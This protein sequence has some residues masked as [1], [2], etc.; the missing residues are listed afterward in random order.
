MVEDFY[1]WPLFILLLLSLG[2]MVIGKLYSKKAGYVLSKVLLILV[3][4]GIVVSVYHDSTQAL[5]FYF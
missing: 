1:V 4:I 3:C 5:H 2:S